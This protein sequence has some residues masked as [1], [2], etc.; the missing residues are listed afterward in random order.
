MPQLWKDGAPDAKQIHT[1][2]PP[3]GN[4]E[5][6]QP[7]IVNGQQTHRLLYYAV[8]AFA[9]SLPFCPSP[10][11]VILKADINVNQVDGRRMCFHCA[12]MYIYLTA[13]SF[14]PSFFWLSSTDPINRLL[15]MRGFLLDV[16]FQRLL[17]H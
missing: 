9:T 13:V 14:Q 8:D 7:T 1:H 4:R 17:K 5:K 15:N 6:E 10:P 3:W 16:K 2:I 11:P 12:C